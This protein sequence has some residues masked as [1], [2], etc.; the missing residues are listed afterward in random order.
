M[1]LVSQVYEGGSLSTY[2]TS[3][4]SLTSQ[5]LQATLRALVEGVSSP[6]KNQTGL[7]RSHPYSSAPFSLPQCPAAEMQIEKCNQQLQQQHVQEGNQSNE[8]YTMNIKPQLD[9][10]KQMQQ[11]RAGGSAPTC[12][13]EDVPQRT[14]PVLSLTMGRLYQTSPDVASLLASPKQQC[15]LLAPPIG[16]PPITTK[17]EAGSNRGMW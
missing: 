6:H 17:V 9:H 13:V 14:A 5:S 12:A 1:V 7:Q 4:M 2:E 15:S 16:L 11:L 3:L 10:H 8:N